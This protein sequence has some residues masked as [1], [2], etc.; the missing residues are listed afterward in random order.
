MLTPGAY[1]ASRF[2]VPVGQAVSV[3]VL[4]E[5]Y[6]GGASRDRTDDLIVAND[7]LSQ[8][9]YS[10]TFGGM[11]ACRC[12]SDY[13]KLPRTPAVSAACLWPL[14]Q[15]LPGGA[16]RHSQRLSIPHSSRSCLAVHSWHSQRLAAAYSKRPSTPHHPFSSTQSTARYLTLYRAF[17]SP[18][19]TP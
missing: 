2:Y 9:S 18:P 8:L 13:T 4:K 15:Q 6:F 3:D 7:A 5:V 10:P 17:T 16:F 11:A 19:P 12:L 1:E 14:R